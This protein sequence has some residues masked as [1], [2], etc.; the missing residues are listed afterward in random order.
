MCCMKNLLF[1]F[2]LAIFSFQGAFAAVGEDLVVAVSAEHSQ[3]SLAIGSPD[4]G[5][6]HGLE[7]ACDV[8]ELSDY[9]P[10][11]LSIPQTI[12]PVPTRHLPCVAFLSIK[13]PTIE[14]PPRG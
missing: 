10:A 6:D 8:E 5:V 7:V 2:L 11:D 3:V 14:P 12:Y 4:D 1:A 9:L 13:L